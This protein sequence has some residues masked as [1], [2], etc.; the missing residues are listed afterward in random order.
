MFSM[1]RPRILLAASALVAALLALAPAARAHALYDYGD[2][3]A[4]RIAALLTP[5]AGREDGFH[6]VQIGDS[7]TAG[8]YF[9]DYLRTELQQRLG[10][11]GIGWAMS[12]YASGQR[13]ARVGYEQEGWELV[14]SRNAG[15]ADYP[16]GGLIAQGTGVGGQL[17]LKTKSDDSP[18]QN[19]VMVVSQAA[20]DPP[21]HIIDADSEVLDVKARRADGAWSEATFTARLPFIVTTEGSP[22]T[23]IGGWWMRGER[24]GAIVSAVGIN[25]SELSQWDRWR[26]GWMDDLA[27]GKPDL[28]ALAYGTNEAFRTN[29]DPREYRRTLE[30]AIDQLRAR[31]PRSAI[32][33][34]G[35]PES[36]SSLKGGVCG[37]RA[38]SLNVV[39]QEQRAVA[40]EKHTLYWDWQQAM[41]GG[42][43][44]RKWVAQNLA[45]KDGVHFSQ[46][47]YERAAGDLLAGLLHLRGAAGSR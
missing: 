38:P 36:L 3:N 17:T 35:A 30:T 18:R 39:Q 24:P 2:R 21:L 14:N 12:M 42:C 8:D 6:M 33:I 11:G 26:S 43:S 5:S 9:T 15:E 28:I 32:L 20:G 40:K 41:G 44:M 23:R 29:L 34:I 37:Q 27:L 22:N 46:E 25:G 16:F 10:D 31:F 1:S 7:H 4:T 45:R 13:L 19:I 47:G